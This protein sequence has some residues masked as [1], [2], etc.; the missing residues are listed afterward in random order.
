MTLVLLDEGRPAL[1]MPR[2]AEGLASRE[3]VLRD[4]LFAHLSALPIDELDPAIGTLVPVARELNLAGVGRID[5]LL[6]DTFGRLII[7]E[8]KL[9]RNPQARREVVGQI[10]DY[11]RE[12]ARYSYDDLQRIVSATTAMPGNALYELA[13]AAGSTLS[14]AAFV[15]RISRDLAAGRFL[16]LIVGDGITEGA[17]KITEFLQAQPGLA[18]TF[19]MVEMALYRFHDPLLGCERVMVQPRLLAKTVD[20]QRIVVRAE[21]P[22]FLVEVEQPAAAPAR[23]SDQGSS[24]LSQRW[25]A[26]ADRLIPAMRFDDPGQMPARNGGIGWLRVPLPGPAHLTVWRS[27]PHQ[28]IGMFARFAGADGLALYDLLASERATIDAEFMATGLT[29]PDWQ[30]SSQEGS[31]ATVWSAPTPWTHEREDDQIAILAPAANQF[32]NSLRPRL[33]AQ[34]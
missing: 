8:C 24:D 5:A 20:I 19:G 4:L 26:F 11:A 3:D 25:R 9:W 2:E 32:V 17:Q 14:E 23:S 27:L 13:R 28:Q 33:L 7:V 22:G 15:D 10:L 29:A 12:L 34:A 21:S 30:V 16:L 1:T 6:I 31:I 18:F